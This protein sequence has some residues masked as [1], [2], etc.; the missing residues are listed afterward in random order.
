M[1]RNQQ[2]VK[3]HLLS[4]TGNDLVIPIGVPDLD[5]VRAFANELHQIG[6]GWSGEVFG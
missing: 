3:V 6:K 5:E 4:K 1:P 2:M